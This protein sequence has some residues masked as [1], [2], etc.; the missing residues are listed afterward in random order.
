MI[1]ANYALESGFVG[2]LDNGIQ[3]LIDFLMLHPKRLPWL[4]SGFVLLAAILIALVTLLPRFRLA[5]LELL[6]TATALGLLVAMIFGTALGLMWLLEPQTGTAP[7]AHWQRLF[8]IEAFQDWLRSEEDEG[9]LT[10]RY[11]LLGSKLNVGWA[12]VA[13]LSG[14]AWIVLE[15]MFITW[16]RGESIVLHQPTRRER[17]VARSILVIRL[18]ISP[19]VIVGQIVVLAWC[20][21]RAA[22]IMGLCP[23][24][25]IVDEP[26]D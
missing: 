4:K 19:V 13:I 25:D 12:D 3:R 14:E 18:L 15:Q 26:A 21:L 1:A 8:N 24:I 2:S 10:T 22:K 17:I 6:G 11:Q 9:S 20:A 16:F 5:A 23:F 7:L